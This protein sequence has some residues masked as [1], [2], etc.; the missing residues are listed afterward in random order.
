[1]DD[2]DGIDD[3]IEQR[4]LDADFSLLL[5]NAHMP[6]ARTHACTHACVRRE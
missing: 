2:Y 5:R 1:M 3:A 4:R 6:H